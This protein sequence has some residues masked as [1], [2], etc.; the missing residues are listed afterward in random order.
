MAL[1]RQF[2][3]VAN[4]IA[5]TWGDLEAFETYMESLLTDKRGNRKGFPPD[6]VAELSAL[7]IH[8]L[9]IERRDSTST[10]VK[11]RA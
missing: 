6:V 7:E 10:G 2:A 4:L 3:R 1:M 11:K 8:R 5:A 9:A